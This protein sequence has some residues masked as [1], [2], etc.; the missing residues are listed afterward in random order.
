MG[1]YRESEIDKQNAKWFQNNKSCNTLQKIAIRQSSIRGLGI[2][3]MEF[4][5]PITVIVGENGSGKSTI[6]SLICCAFHN[7][8][9]FCP[10]SLVA[11]KK[12]LRITIHI[13]IF[14]LLLHLSV[15]LWE[16]LR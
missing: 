13:V 6:L 8:T 14:L 10:M 16:I 15:V 1:N 3:E 4:R 9:S 11:N 7:E 2:F 5:Y 12:K